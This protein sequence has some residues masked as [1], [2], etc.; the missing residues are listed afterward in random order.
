MARLKYNKYYNQWRILTV[1]VLV[2]SKL[3]GPLR[4][5]YFFRPKRV[6][7]CSPGNKTLPNQGKKVIANVVL[8]SS[9]F[10]QVTSYGGTLNQPPLGLQLTV[11]AFDNSTL[12]PTTSSSDFE[13]VSSPV[14]GGVVAGVAVFNLSEP[15]FVVLSSNENLD[16]LDQ[17][18]GFKKHY[19]T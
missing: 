8:P 9:L 1:I 2:R 6:F 14:I 17:R 11:V 15:I 12:F 13:A 19:L 4:I 10:Q 7:H 18:S 5:I 3:D 16:N